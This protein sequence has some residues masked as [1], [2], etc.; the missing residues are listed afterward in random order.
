VCWISELVNEAQLRGKCVVAKH[1]FVVGLQVINSQ[2]VCT[3]NGLGT[4]V[5]SLLTLVQSSLLGFALK[6]NKPISQYCVLPSISFSGSGCVFCAV[7]FDI[8]SGQPYSLRL[9]LLLW[10]L[11]CRAKNNKNG[12]EFLGNSRCSSSTF[13]GNNAVCIII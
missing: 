8:L 11:I 10:W 12:K 13:N 1:S 9:Y 3:D 2:C 5:T 4:S 6:G 7:S